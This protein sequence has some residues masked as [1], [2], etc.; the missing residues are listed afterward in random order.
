[1]VDSGEWFTYIGCKV[2]SGEWFT[3]GG[4]LIQNSDIKSEQKRRPKYNDKCREGE[5]DV[6]PLENNNIVN[7]R[8][9]Y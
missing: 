5:V 3:Y 2:D 6:E 8:W 9:N 7:L 4:G 1:M